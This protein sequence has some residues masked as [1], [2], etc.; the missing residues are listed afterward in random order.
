M[1]WAF[2]SPIPDKVCSVFASAVLILTLPVVADLVVFFIEVAFVV[3]LS[4]A[5]FTAFVAE[6][7]AEVAFAAVFSFTVLTALVADALVDVTF[8]AVLSFTVLTAFVADA[9]VEETL[10]VTELFTEETASVAVDFAELLAEVTACVAL[11]FIDDNGFA[12]SA[13]EVEETAIAIPSASNDFN[14]FMENP[15]K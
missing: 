1:A 4:L 2:A 15:Y 10:S 5:V 8:D 11:S 12:V 14:D 9:F 13:K 7:F 3:A 6:V